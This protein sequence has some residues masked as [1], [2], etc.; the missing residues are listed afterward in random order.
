MI[1]YIETNIIAI[2]VAL[3]LL[4][5]GRRAVSKNETSQIILNLMMVLLILL[6]ISDIAAYCFRGKSYIGV[7]VSNIL[8]FSV[9]A[10]GAYAWCGFIGVK[11]NYITSLDKFFLFSGIPVFLL[12]FSFLLNP[13]TEFIFSVDEEL[14]YHRG[15]GVLITWIVEW[16]YMLAALSLN[17]WAIWHEKRKN[18]K[19]EYQGYLIFALPIAAA[20]VCQMLFYGITTIQIGFMGGCL[21]AFVNQQ[22]YL[23]QRDELTG[24]NN[25]NSFVEYRDSF[26][27]RVR[28][29]T[30]SIYMM[31]A[32]HFK[33]INDSYGHLKGDQALKDIS[34]VL[35]TSAEAITE[36]HIRLYRYA[37]DEF[38]IVAPEIA[39]NGVDVIK[40]LISE[41]L[42]EMNT[43]NQK[44]G[45]KYHLSL[46][47][48]CAS[49]LCSNE[50]EFDNLFR[51]A[52][53]EM[54][55]VKKRKR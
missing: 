11:L 12:C 13:W 20:A 25:R 33:M 29:L 41:N 54:Y 40:Q 55:R 42:L 26:I 31:D 27:N 36:T 43:Y 5:Q 37:G 9:M 24:L 52:D 10:I 23:V 6:G 15:P 53:E 14:Y 22:Y 7:E 48:G 8:Y 46:S 34:E 49:G 17:L 19:S 1:Y 32:D 44:K 47:V 50:K 2:L 21:L 28:P 3:I 18:K 38:V 30:L 45:E 35:K 4:Y 39:Y 51:Q 16:G